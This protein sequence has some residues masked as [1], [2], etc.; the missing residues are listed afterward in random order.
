MSF[1]LLGMAHAQ[2]SPQPR[3]VAPDSR[4]AASFFLLEVGEPFV[5]VPTGAGAL[6]P[7]LV[8]LGGLWATYGSRHWYVRLDAQACDLSG[9]VS[10][11]A[12]DSARRDAFASVLGWPQD[13]VVLRLS[14]LRGGYLQTHL[15]VINHG[16]SGGV[17]F[18]A[19]RRLAAGTAVLIDGDGI[20]IVRC[21]C[22]N[23]LLSLPPQDEPPVALLAEAG[24]LAPDSAVV[25]AEDD[26]PL[27]GE[28]DKAPPGADEGPLPGG[29]ELPGAVADTGAAGV[30]DNGDGDDEDGAA[31]GGQDQDAGD[32]LD[33]VLSEP[34][35]SPGDVDP[36]SPVQIA[37]GV[38]PRAPPV[39]TGGMI[40][41]FPEEELPLPIALFVVAVLPIADDLGEDEELADLPSDELGDGGEMPPIDDEFVAPAVPLPAA[42]WL[43]AGGLLLLGAVR[44][45][46]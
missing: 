5:Q 14:A 38:E 3:L 16:F 46:R 25:L 45:R 10:G 36:N 44:R 26:V 7:Q 1:V 18:G 21:A 19:E 43:F 24:E 4:G 20:P 28:A 22:G 29:G 42:G 30:G 33:S 12:N 11:I 17:P 40:G 34:G 15:D 23:P 31:D 6:D 8:T 13:E 35:G 32:L 37:T 39:P 27:I 2:D 41:E 9:L